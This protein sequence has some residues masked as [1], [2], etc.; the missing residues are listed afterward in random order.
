MQLTDDQ[1]AQLKKRLFG[2]IVNDEKTSVP[3][4]FQWMVPPDSADH[5]A[6]QLS[7]AAVD[8][9]T[10]MNATDKTVAKPAAKA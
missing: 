4:Q 5:L 2:I 3:R 10:K 6:A 8:E 7:A 1:Q 9:L